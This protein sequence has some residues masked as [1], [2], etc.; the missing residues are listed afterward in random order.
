MGEKIGEGAS[1][2]ISKYKVNGSF[3]AAK[4]FKQKISRRKIYKVANKL[5]QLSHKNVVR[6]DGFCMDPVSLIFEYCALMLDGETVHNVSQFINIRNED[7]QFD[8]SERMDLIIQATRGLQALHDHHIIHKDFKPSN[9]LLCGTEHNPLVKIAD[10]DDISEIKNTITSTF[11][12]VNN[13]L[14]GMTLAYTAEEICLN[15]VKCAS[16]QSDVYSW[17]IT[18]YEIMSDKTSAWSSK[19]AIVND[20]LILEALKKGDRPDVDDLKKLYPNDISQL[21]NIMTDSWQTVPELRPS[22]SQVLRVL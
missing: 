10:F 3:V 9:L 16:F 22:I 14:V 12:N 19:L 18:A 13:V 5:A 21:V 1:S 8:L 20:C 6:F 2:N 4:V 7:D 17:A 15:K 11:T